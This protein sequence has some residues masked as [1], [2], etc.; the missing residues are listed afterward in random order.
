MNST[1]IKMHG[2][3]IKTDTYVL[4][5]LYFSLCSPI[6]G[7]KH[8]HQVTT[9]VYNHLHTQTLFYPTSHIILHSNHFTW[10][11]AVQCSPLFQFPVRW[12]PMYC[13]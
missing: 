10:W 3:T 4:F 7:S 5:Y 11:L 8:V 9:H 1:Y 12:G 13:S 2:A 6:R